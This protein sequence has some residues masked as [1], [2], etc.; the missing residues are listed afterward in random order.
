MG[1][2]LTFCFMFC[3]GEASHKNINAVGCIKGPNNI[4]LWKGYIRDIFRDYFMTNPSVIGG[5]GHVVEIDQSSFLRY[6]L[7]DTAT[8]QFMFGGIDVTTNEGFLVPV[9][10]CEAKT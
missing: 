2:V 10:N 4:V 6:D 1:E 8:M 9:G 3:S 7:G 5:I